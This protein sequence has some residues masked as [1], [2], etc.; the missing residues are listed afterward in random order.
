MFK[1]ILSDEFQSYL[2]I[3][4]LLYFLMLYFL[5]NIGK[6]VN[7]NS[8][9]NVYNYNLEILGDFNGTII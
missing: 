2:L 5:T 9:F 6:K 4:L 7:F 1:N 3:N 8:K